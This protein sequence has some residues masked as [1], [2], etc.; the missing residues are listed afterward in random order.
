MFL[1]II[2]SQRKHKSEII[3]FSWI[4]LGTPTTPDFGVL[5]IYLPDIGVIVVLV[6]IWGVKWDVINQNER[7][8]FF[9]S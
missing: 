6:A 5:V 3:K 7:F 2:I 9:F 8:V 4:C 1:H